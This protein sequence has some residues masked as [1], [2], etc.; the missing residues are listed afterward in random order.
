[1]VDTTTRLDTAFNVQ[2]AFYAPLTQDVRA[3]DPYTPLLRAYDNARANFRYF[4]R[5]CRA[6]TPTFTS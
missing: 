6:G 2:P 5:S 1:M 4:W 3:K